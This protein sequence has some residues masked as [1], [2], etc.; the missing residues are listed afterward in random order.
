MQFKK[1][2]IKRKKERKKKSILLFVFF[3]KS[4]VLSSSLHVKKNNLVQWRAL[5]AVIDKVIITRFF[6]DRGWGLWNLDVLQVQE[7][8]LH[9][10]VQK[11]V[12][13]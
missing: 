7:A 11:S 6:W 8:E 5:V 10:H 12:Q 3:P 2:R 9:L 13:V 1:K 4:F